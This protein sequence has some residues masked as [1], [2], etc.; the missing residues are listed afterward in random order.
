M[1]ELTDG[2]KKR[3]ANMA[4]PFTKATAA[5]MGRRGGIAAQKTIA[6]KKHLRDSLK[7]ILALEPG[8]RNKSKL[9]DLGIPEDQM[10]NEMLVA[11]AMFQKAIK[12]DV[13]A[14]EYI[15]DMT[16][17]RPQTKLDKART[18]LMNAQA[19]AITEQTNGGKSELTK[20][21]ELLSSIDR[22]AEDKDGTEC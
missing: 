12:G 6:K 16:G 10:T 18:N 1:A 17:Q 3:L 5:E 4:K 11:V 2:K 9:A 7:V 22:I 8:D 21:D 13:R 20:L 19:K 15:R 14:A